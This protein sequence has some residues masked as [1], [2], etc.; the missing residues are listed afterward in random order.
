MKE[1]HDQLPAVPFKTL[2]M[3]QEANKE[4]LVFLE[5][6]NFLEEVKMPS[7]Y[8]GEMD[9]RLIVV[10]KGMA[11]IKKTTED[12]LHI[13]RIRSN[14]QLKKNAHYIILLRNVEEE[15]EDD[16]A[17]KI[18]LLLNRKTINYEIQDSKNSLYLLNRTWKL[19]QILK[20]NLNVSK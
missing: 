8:I 20:T 3:I 5:L 13:I 17:E 1:P 15:Q 4:K 11:Y 18:L 6:F 16:L 12:S 19:E 14:K 2:D 7:S 10:I 9:L